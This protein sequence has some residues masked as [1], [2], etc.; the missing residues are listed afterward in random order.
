MEKRD[1][2]RHAEPEEEGQAWVLLGHVVLVSQDGLDVHGVSQVLQVSEISGDVQQRRD[3]LGHHHRKRVASQLRGQLHGL[4]HA[5]GLTGVQLHGFLLRLD[6]HV[7]EGL[8][9]GI[10]QHGQVDKVFIVMDAPQR[11][12]VVKNIR[13]SLEL[14]V[15]FGEL[16]TAE[17]QHHALHHTVSA[18]CHEDLASSLLKGQVP[19]IHQL[20]DLSHVGQA[21]RP[22]VLGVH[23]GVAA[24]AVVGVVQTGLQAFV[25]FCGQTLIKEGRCG[26]RQNVV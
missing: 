8:A 17:T 4:I 10:L 24:E 25:L 11:V 23:G 13:V 1:E 9:L 22:Q 26:G 12:A 6:G 5:A 19:E 16:Q 20:Q 2:G 14:K 7:Q 21:L 3:G 15:V 18:C